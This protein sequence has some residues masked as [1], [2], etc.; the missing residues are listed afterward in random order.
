MCDMRNLRNMDNI[1]F[2]GPYAAVMK[3]AFQFI[4]VLGV[5]LCFFARN[6]HAGQ[7]RFNIIDYTTDFILY[8]DKYPADDMRAKF[9]WWLDYEQKYSKYLDAIYWS[10]AYPG[11]YESHRKKILWKRLPALFDATQQAKYLS[12][13]MPLFLDKLSKFA[14]SF[15]RE[16]FQVDVVLAISPVLIDAKTQWF[17]NNHNMV[18]INSL[19]SSFFDDSQTEIILAHETFHSLQEQILLRKK[20]KINYASI[21][22][23]I[24]AEGM[25]TYFSSLYL[26]HADISAVLLLSKKDYD[27]LTSKERVLAQDI[28]EVF[29]SSNR[30]IIKSYFAYGGGQYPPRSGYYIS[31]VIIKRLTNKHDFK[32]LTYLGPDELERLVKNELKLIAEGL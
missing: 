14:D 10:D 12:K 9:K 21:A 24:V 13:N 15:C 5:F 23:K 27:N 2:G 18:H 6:A 29:E 8:A 28:Y 31:Y 3:M 32:V 25:A 4:G 22:G 26:N 20:E 7:L 17:G 16:Q 11:I 1:K 30:K 19:S